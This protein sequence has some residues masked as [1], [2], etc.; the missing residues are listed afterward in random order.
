MNQY[1]SL[2]QK[3][4]FFSKYTPFI[5]YPKAV[6]GWIVHPSGVEAVGNGENMLPIYL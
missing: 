5:S 6:N 4:V 3:V 1:F 2:V